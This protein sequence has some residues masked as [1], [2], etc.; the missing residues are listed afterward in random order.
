[1]NQSLNDLQSKMYK[2]C[3][4]IILL[5]IENIYIYFK[6]Y[7]KEIFKVLN[8]KKNPEIHFS[9][10]LQCLFSERFFVTIK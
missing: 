7:I 3:M 2:I 4:L 10:L 8:L 6:E 5:R 9:L 1:M